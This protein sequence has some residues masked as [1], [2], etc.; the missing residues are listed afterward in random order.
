VLD[1]L[2]SVAYLP[3]FI[4]ECE[5]ATS[6]ELPPIFRKATLVVVGLDMGEAL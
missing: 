3:P 5:R 2:L 4:H 6:A 1:A